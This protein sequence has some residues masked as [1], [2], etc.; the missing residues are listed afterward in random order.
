MRVVRDRWGIPHIY[1]SSQDDLFLAQGFVQAQD[2]LFQI[3]LWRRSTLGR[4]SEILGPDFIARDRMTRLMAYRGPLDV[5]WTS[6]SPDTQ[7]IAEQF[8]R[9]VN[10]WIEIAR[11]DPPEEFRVAGYLP[12]PWQATDLLSRGEAFTMS[13][14]ALA[15]V[16]RARIMTAVG[17]DTA[18]R[19]LP[20]DPP[21]AVRVAPGIDLSVLEL[22]SCRKVSRRIAAPPAFGS[23]DHPR[24]RVAAPSRRQTKAATTGWSAVSVPQPA[25]LSWRTIRTVRSITRRFGTWCISRRL[26]GTSSERSCRGFRV[27]PSVT[28]SAW[29]GD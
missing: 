23:G 19:L 17:A 2:R 16:F 3:D 13:G 10:Q 21:V 20:P 29:P 24:A 8:V 28:T 9:G 11:R 27:W 4:L 26:A 25:T 5:E 1:A 22:T 18:E 15:E 6:Y 14:N 7:R 12:E